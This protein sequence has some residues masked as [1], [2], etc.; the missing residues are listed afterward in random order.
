M[1]IKLVLH[2]KSY[3]PILESLERECVFN[4]SIQMVLRDLIQPPAISDFTLRV[5][6]NVNVRSG[7]WGGCKIVSWPFW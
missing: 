6:W 4:I 5:W 3:G 1:K 2:L 7:Q